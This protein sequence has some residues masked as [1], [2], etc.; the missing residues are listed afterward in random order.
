MPSRREAHA[1]APSSILPGRALA[2]LVGLA[3]GLGTLLSAGSAQALPLLTLWGSVRGLYGSAL[4]D[5][6]VNGYGPGFGL[7]A[8]VTLPASLYLGASFDYFVG[9]S[10]SVEGIDVSASVLQVLANVGYDAGLGPIT[11][12]PNLGFGLAQTEAEL[13][14][15]STSDGDFAVSPGVEAFIGLGLLT[16]SGEVR[17]NHVFAPGDRDAIILGLG[18]GLAL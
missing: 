17:Y 8:G 2:P 7:R 1:V 12:R 15:S 16:L 5:A 13:D 6:T 11:L 3:L 10:E 4:G 18:L 9:E 14:G